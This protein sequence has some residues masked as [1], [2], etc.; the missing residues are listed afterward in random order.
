MRYTKSITV[1]PGRLGLSVTIVSGTICGARI[2]A[3]RPACAFSDKVAIGDIIVEI[4]GKC[5][6][7]KEDFSLEGVHGG[8]LLIV[9]GMTASS[10]GKT[11]PPPSTLS[12]TNKNQRSKKLDVDVVR[13]ND[14]GPQH[15]S[16]PPSP[17]K[18]GKTKTRIIEAL[19]NEKSDIHLLIGIRNSSGYT[20]V[21]YPKIRERYATT[22]HDMKHFRPNVKRLLESM[23]KMTGP[24]KETVKARSEIEPWYTSSKKTSLAYTLLHDLYRFNTSEINCMTAEQ[25]WSSHPLFKRYE[26]K[27]FKQYNANMKKLVTKKV[28]AASMENEIYL[29]DMQNHKKK[30]VTCRGTP[31]WNTHAAK[32][33]LTEDVKAGIDRSMKPKILWESRVEYQAFPYDH[34]RKRVYEIRSK[35]LAAPYWQVKRNKNGRELHRLETNE[36]RK[37]WA[38][39]RL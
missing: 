19:K 20:N 29:E 6:R 32:I 2:D 35:Q 37:V 38:L 34:F 24:F 25:I 15:A 5:V 30:L 10:G 13:V 18:T 39:S 22:M 1:G 27:D 7:T 8:K 9:S 14:K 11:T 12:K 31:F 36:M 3:I 16:P 17:W 33:L 4:N 26:L 21:N 23:I 28:T